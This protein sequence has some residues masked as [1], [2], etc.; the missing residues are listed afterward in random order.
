MCCADGAT[1]TSFNLF[2]NPGV[3]E[4]PTPG[5]GSIPILLMTIQRNKEVIEFPKVPKTG[6]W[7][8]QN[9]SRYKTSVLKVISPSL[10]C[11][12]CPCIQG[13]SQQRSLYH[14]ISK[15]VL[16][17]FSSTPSYSWSLLW[18][19]KKYYPTWNLLI[20]FP[21]TIAWNQRERSKGFGVSGDNNQH[22]WP[23]LDK[24]TWWFQRHRRR[25][26]GDP[27][28][29]NMWHALRLKPAADDKWKKTFHT[30]WM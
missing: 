30:E 1:G 9:S 10:C 2:H 25:D 17:I 5:V 21:Y 3:V 22:L 18:S 11:H 23:S 7:W 8:S 27:G 4:N 28:H 19:H 13:K 15:V 26:L 20:P 14:S 24:Y 6:A 12:H 16:R 29:G